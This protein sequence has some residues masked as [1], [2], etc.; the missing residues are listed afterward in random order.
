MVSLIVSAYDCL[1]RASSASCS[2]ATYWYSRAPIQHFTTV[3]RDATRVVVH[4]CRISSSRGH[5]AG[6]PEDRT[7][8]H[9][10]MGGHIYYELAGGPG[11]PSRAGQ[12]WRFKMH[13]STGQGGAAIV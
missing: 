4:V 3:F 11:A 5:V 9:E 1:L 2:A 13:R 10:P 8:A 7:R 6:Q 12:C